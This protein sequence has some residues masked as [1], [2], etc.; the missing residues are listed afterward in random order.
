MLLGLL[1]IDIWGYLSIQNLPK[2][3]HIYLAKN[4]I[5]LE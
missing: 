1:E 3:D 2:M 4:D 5:Q